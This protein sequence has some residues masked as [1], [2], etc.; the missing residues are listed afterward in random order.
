[1]SGSTAA[2]SGLQSVGSR[3]IVSRLVV[4]PIL[5]SARVIM[6]IRRLAL[7]VAVGA[8]GCISMSRSRSGGV[9]PGAIPTGEQGDGTSRGFPQ[10]TMVSGSP[11]HWAAKVVSYKSPPNELTAEDQS[12]CSVDPRTFGQVQRGDRQSCAWRATPAR[13]WASMLLGR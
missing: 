1:V 7:L 4:P 6:P 11:E 3:C 2:Q 12:R 13:I 5:T 8:A 9:I 10:P